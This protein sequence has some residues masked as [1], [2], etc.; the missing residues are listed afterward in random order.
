M[1]VATVQLIDRF[2]KL[3][4]QAF[5]RI[6][7]INLRNLRHKRLRRRAALDNLQCPSE[8]LQVWGAV[9]LCV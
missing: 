5:P 2:R 9:S 7:C 6:H 8:Y 3:I 4:L 1:M